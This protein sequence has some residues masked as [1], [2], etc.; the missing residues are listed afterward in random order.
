MQ[1]RSTESSRRVYVTLLALLAAFVLV[2]GACGSGGSSD[3]EANKETQQD[4]GRDVVDEGEPQQGGSLVVAVNAESNGFSPYYSQ[5]GDAGQVVAGTMYEALTRF[6]DNDEVQPW[7]IEGWESNAEGT[8][9]TITTK[10]GITFHNGEEFNGDVVK[11]NI[12]AAVASPLSGL[13]LQ[14]LFGDIVVEDDNRTVV[15]NTLIPWFTFPQFMAGAVALQAAPAMDEIEDKGVTEPIGTGPYK[16]DEW[17][18]DNFLR[19]TAYDDYWGDGP[20]YLDQIEFRPITDAAAQANSLES[21]EIDMAFTV[22][23]QNIIDFRDK[24]GFYTVEDNFQ[25]ETFVMLNTGK[26]PFDNINAR[27]AL[28]Y[29]TN[30]Q[31]VVDILGEGV[32]RPVTSPYQEGTKWAVEDDGYVEY[33]PAK[34]EEALAAYTEETGEETLSFNFQGLQT[35]EDAEVMQVLTAQWAG[36]GIDA[37]IETLEQTTYITK[38]ALG[39]YEANWFRNFGYRDPSAHRV[40]WHCDF[41]NGVTEPD[42]EIKLSINFTQT[43]EEDL[44]A[45]SDVLQQG[46]TE[47]ER[48]AANAEAVRIINEELPYIWLYNTPYAIL[49]RDGVHGLNTARTLGFA[50]FDPKPWMGDLWQTAS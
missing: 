28:A 5:L 31:A 32:T 4:Q 6:D 25:E 26:P 30:Q 49:A 22:S 17:Q 19:V 41:A 13:A 1:V 23:T 7:L 27:K 21:G 50:G 14:G 43:C 10:E 33:D 46:K 34:A 29:G 9:W 18:Q 48:L 35:V 8:Q 44:D 2:A 38:T 12:E 15:I 42:G 24:D 36:L 40:F 45:A 20:P 47:E 16:F 3:D 11:T 39:Q 37:E